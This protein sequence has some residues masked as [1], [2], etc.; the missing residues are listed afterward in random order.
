LL[1]NGPVKPGCKFPPVSGAAMDDMLG[2]LRKH[3]GTL[4]GKRGV[5]SVDIGYVWK[6]GELTDE[7]GL[8]AHVMQKRPRHAVD[9]ADLVPQQIGAWRVDVLAS[10]RRHYA[11]EAFD[12]LIGGIETNSFRI[13]GRGTLGAIVHHDTEDGAFALS[14]YHVFGRGLPEN[15]IGGAVHQPAS[16]LDETRYGHVFAVDVTLDCAIAKV[17]GPRSTRPAIL[18]LVDHVA[19]T[20]SPRLGLIVTKSGATTGVTSGMI[21][22]VGRRDQF[23]IVPRPESWGPIADRGDSGAVW[24]NTTT[25]N[26]VGLHFGGELNDSDITIRAWA[27]NIEQVCKRLHIHF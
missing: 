26:A 10:K 25:N 12:P 20:E 1:N 19:G 6:G 24:I 3:A 9:Q 14:N 27:K 22:G 23:T 5:H 11:G 15:G 2:V 21:E 13:G 4:L 8:R 18:N 16:G 17:D 7:I